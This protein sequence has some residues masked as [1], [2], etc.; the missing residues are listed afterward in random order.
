MSAADKDVPGS[1]DP[2]WYAS[3]VEVYGNRREQ[4]AAAEKRAEAA[5]AKQ[6]N[7]HTDAGPNCN[8]KAIEIWEPKVITAADLIAAPPEPI[9]YIVPGLLPPGLAVI[10][11]KPK[12]GKSLLAADWALAVSSGGTVWGREVTRAGVLYLDLENSRRRIYD[13]YLKLHPNMGDVPDMGWIL[14]WR[15]GNR[16]AFTQLLDD[17][18]DVK[19]VIIDIWKK[20]C[21][22]QPRG[23]EQYDFETDELQWLAKE[24]NDR[25][26]AIVLVFH[27]VKSPP[28]DGDPFSAISGSVAITGNADTMFV[29][30]REGDVTKLYQR[31]RD[32]G[33]AS[34]VLRMGEDLRFRYVCDGDQTAS[35]EQMK[36]L[37]AIYHGDRLPNEL[38]NALGVSRQA[39]W[40]M[41]HRLQE[42]GYITMPG[43][44]PSL[45]QIAR[46]MVEAM[47]GSL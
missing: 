37:T 34:Y 17:R 23:I 29:L 30:R 22:A 13:R 11:G 46:Q 25:G 2:A 19:L 42:S 27:T 35:E 31:G 1:V 18:P 14:E 21:G 33:D 44:V 3:N 32:S 6:G 40:K 41:I 4:R 36:Y 20:F 12:G 28:L 10:G 15:R 38:M 45:T 16:S 26:I 24:A 9:R 39:V 7:G 5:R 47:H 8:T 43:G